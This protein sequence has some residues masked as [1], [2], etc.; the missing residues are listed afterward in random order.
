LEHIVAK[1][2]KRMSTTSLKNA[3]CRSYKVSAGQVDVSK[4]NIEALYEEYKE[5]VLRKFKLELDDI[6]K[7]EEENLF[8]NESEIQEE[9]Y[10]REWKLPKYFRQCQLGLT[11]LW[12]YQRSLRNITRFSDSLGKR[13]SSSALS[14]SSSP[15]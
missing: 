3:R 13:F 10:V 15:I 8:P 6:L 5:I 1:E 4:R 14:M 2:A 7:A 11:R 12:L 9:K